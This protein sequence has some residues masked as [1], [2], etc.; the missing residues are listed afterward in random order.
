MNCL[1]LTFLIQAGWSHVTGYN[2]DVLDPTFFQKSGVSFGYKVAQ[3][4]T[5]SDKMIIVTAPQEGRGINETGSVYKC[6]YT[7]QSC[8]ALDLQA[9]ENAVNSSIGLTLAS[10]QSLEPR[11]LVCGPTVSYSCV[12]SAYFT[13]MCYLLDHKLHQVQQIPK[14]LQECPKAPTDIAV[15]FDGSD[16]ISASDFIKMKTFL[17]DMIQLFKE[18]DVR[19]AVIQYSDGWELHFNF[20]MYITLQNVNHSLDNITQL[21]SGTRTTL[22]MEYVIDNV[23]TETNGNRPQASKV[24][25]VVTDGENIGAK[26]TFAEVAK[27]A[28]NKNITRY[29]IGVGNIFN[30]SNAGEELKNISSHPGNVLKVNSFEGLENIQQKLQNNIVAIEGSQELQNVTSFQTEMSQ[31]GFSAILAPDATVLGAVGAYQ[32]SGGIFEY[33]GDKHSVFINAS[34][35]YTNM[36]DSY[37][38][39]AVKW[40]KHDSATMYAVGAPRYLHIGKV[41]VFSRVKDGAG[42]QISKEISGDQIGSYF[43]AELCA[44]DLDGDTN[45]DLL[46]IGAPHYIRERH[47]GLVKVC[48]VLSQEAFSCDGELQGKAGDPFGRFGASITDIMDINGDNI[49]DVVVGAPLENNH[50]GSIYLFHGQ[51][52][53]INSE[54]SQHIKGAQIS[55]TLKYFGQSVHGIMD[56]TDDNLT[57]IAVGALGRAVLLRSVPIIKIS[58]SLKFDPEEVLSTQFEC[59]SL[60]SQQNVA[61]T[62]KVCFNATMVTKNAVGGLPVNI[63]FRL[64]LTRSAVFQ[65]QQPE[66]NKTISVDRTYICEDHEIYFKTCLKDF[67]SAVKL[68]M[69]F[70]LAAVASGNTLKPVLHEK[71]QTNYSALI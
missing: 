54:Y 62:A 27:K 55:S 51:K 10:Q 17:K 6:N 57:D 33:Q 4:G 46:L 59:S 50:H 30:T 53:G 56:L 60:F 43:G 31:E 68:R 13:G 36:T 42:W 37:L 63:S 47:G 12:T 58:A 22:A 70:S 2:I 29:A 52:D 39:Y 16:S 64:Y 1:F 25:V 11:L 20:S 9:P 49:A 7:K 28:N 45:T 32:W 67:S 71:C 44:V 69:N 66:I 34:S 61:S 14:T 8:E 19:F 65:A 26:P 15:L 24:L 35:T 48:H 38:G 21:K 5:G 40:L 18:K 41:V 23:F 3:F